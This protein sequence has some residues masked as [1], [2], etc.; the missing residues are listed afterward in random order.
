MVVNSSSGD[1]FAPAVTKPRQLS[2]KEKTEAAE[3]WQRQDPDRE[4][5]FLKELQGYV[6]VA[7]I[8]AA[9]LGPIAERYDIPKPISALIRLYPQF[10]ILTTALSPVK[11]PALCLTSKIDDPTYWAKFRR[12]SADGVAAAADVNPWSIL[13]VANSERPFGEN[14]V[15]IFESFLVAT[16]GIGTMKDLAAICAAFKRVSG[17]SFQGFFN[18]LRPAEFLKHP[19]AAVRFT[20]SWTNDEPPCLYCATRK[21]SYPLGDTT[22]ID[23]AIVRGLLPI[24]ATCLPEQIDFSKLAQR[25]HTTIP[26]VQFSYLAALRQAL[27]MKLDAKNAERTLPR[28]DMDLARELYIEAKNGL[29]I[30]ASVIS[31][32]EKLFPELAK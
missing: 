13:G 24:V 17:V 28:L 1:V 16:Y 15:Q 25:F 21:M 2:Q 5:A 9:L 22:D 20:W 18:G 4:R 6:S 29:A 3:F 27:R 7:P 23:P 11:S 30:Y 14:R 26:T 32:I 10:K 12:K 31:K 19:L 8:H